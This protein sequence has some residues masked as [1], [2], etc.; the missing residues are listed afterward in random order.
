[1]RREGAAVKWGQGEGEGVRYI[2]HSRNDVWPVRPFLADNVIFSQGPSSQDWLALKN[3]LEWVLTLDSRLYLP[4]A[5]I[6]SVFAF[7][8]ANQVDKAFS[9]LNKHEG[10]SPMDKQALE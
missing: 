9:A 10:N 4:F 7:L 8:K 1:M 3:T 2:T 6:T 5:V